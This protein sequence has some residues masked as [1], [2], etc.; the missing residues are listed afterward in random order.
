MTTVLER[1]ESNR[2]K[3][4][5]DRRGIQEELANELG[6]AKIPHHGR[7]SEDFRETNQ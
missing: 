2:S 6:N 1:L 3:Y 4:R 5:N 7:A